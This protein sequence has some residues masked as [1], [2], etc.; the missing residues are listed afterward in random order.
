MIAPELREFIDRAIVPIL[1]QEY[2]EELR[3]QPAST[4]SDEKPHTTSNAENP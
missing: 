2:L 3:Q 1:V 4:P